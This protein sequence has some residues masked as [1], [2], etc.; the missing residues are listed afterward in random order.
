MGGS[1]EVCLLS[2]IPGA[3]QGSITPFYISHLRRLTALI[4]YIQCLR[5]VAR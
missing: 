5:V 1:A 3:P 2:R 4:G